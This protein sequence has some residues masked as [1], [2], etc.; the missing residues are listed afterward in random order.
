LSATLEDQRIEAIARAELEEGRTSME[1][2]G[3]SGTTIKMHRHA[4][5]DAMVF[6]IGGRYPQC[7]DR[8]IHATLE[9][10]PARLGWRLEATLNAYLDSGD[11]DQ[12]VRGLG[13]SRVEGYD[14]AAK[15]ARLLAT[16]AWIAVRDH[17][18][19]GCREGKRP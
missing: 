6:E 13:D 3:L 5:T 2:A 18:L 9:I 7:P 11:H 19:H 8:D 12:E 1:K 16:A 4:R 17:V 10:D 15:Q 14:S